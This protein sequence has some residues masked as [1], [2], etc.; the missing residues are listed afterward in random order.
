MFFWECFTLFLLLG[1]MY[2]IFEFLD[3]LFI[4]FWAV[5]CWFFDCIF[6]FLPVVY[7]FVYLL[8]Y[9]VEYEFY[10]DYVGIA[11]SLITVLV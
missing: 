6:H 8:F 7:H 5:L 4:L 2:S 1:A 9:V 3:F 11:Y 10:D